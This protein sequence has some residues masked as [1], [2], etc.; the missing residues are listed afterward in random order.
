[1]KETK[2]IDDVNKEILRL[3]LTYKI[4]SSQTSFVCVEDRD[5]QV[6]DSMEIS[7]IDATQPKSVSAPNQIQNLP[8]PKS[9][10]SS[11]SRY[12]GGAAPRRT[13]S[14]T[15]SKLKKKRK[16]RSDLDKT[17][18]TPFGFPAELASKFVG[19]PLLTYVFKVRKFSKIDSTIKINLIMGLTNLN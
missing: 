16:D 12:T 6:I 5:E 10:S 13:R 17:L 2:D 18:I 9:T 7:R 11:T 4:A 14:T 15:L 19:D 3:G 8:V 1:M